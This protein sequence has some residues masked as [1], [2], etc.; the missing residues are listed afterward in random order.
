VF[1]T[2][3]GGGVKWENLLGRSI[4]SDIAES[5]RRQHQ[6]DPAGR[7]PRAARPGVVRRLGGWL[8]RLVAPVVSLVLYDT[9]RV[10]MN[11]EVFAR[12]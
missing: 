10:G 9:A 4:H 11:L 12:K 7:A 3:T 6:G 5:Y 2:S 8:K 1:R